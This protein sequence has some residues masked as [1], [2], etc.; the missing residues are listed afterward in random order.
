M[1]MSGTIDHI[2]IATN[3]LD[4]HTEFWQALGL[5]QGKDEV[6]EEQGVRIRFFDSTENEARIELLEPIGKDT[7]IGRFIS[8]RG[9]GIQ[10]IAIR[11]ENIES[12]IQTLTELGVLMIDREPKIGAGGSKIAFI[13]P[14]STGGV[15]V[16][17]V[18][19]VNMKE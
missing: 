13:H 17:L 19:R 1:K 10:Q 7:P 14:K 5:I 4:E 6:N 11:V 9:E 2:G 12:T 3:N 15:L 8:S 18:Q 16:E